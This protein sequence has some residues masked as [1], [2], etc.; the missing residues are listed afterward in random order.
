MLRI[1][2]SRCGN[3]LDQLLLAV[4]IGIH[5]KHGVAGLEIVGHIAFTDGGIPVLVGLVIRVSLARV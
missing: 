4:Q 2:Q 3:E 1:I 5:V